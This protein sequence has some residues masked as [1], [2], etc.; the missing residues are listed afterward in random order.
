M[1]K[2]YLIDTRYI[3]QYSY[4]VTNIDEKKLRP[5]IL[6]VQKERLE[7]VLGTTLYEKIIDDFDG[8]DPDDSGTGPQGLYKTLLDSYVLDFIMVWVEWEYTFHST[9]QMTNK[10]TG[11]NNDENISSNSTEDN[12]NLR[13]KIQ[14]TAYQ[15]QRKMI[16][17]LQDNKDDLPEYCDTPEDEDHQTIRPTKRGRSSYDDFMSII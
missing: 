4:I 11:K 12:N 9:S 1:A 8:Y 7:P 10:T 13:D 16:G 2:T 6:R 3:E 14:K 17:W 5:T 15:Y